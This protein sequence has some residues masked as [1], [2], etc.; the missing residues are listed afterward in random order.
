MFVVVSEEGDARTGIINTKHGEIQTPC[1]LIL[2]RRGGLLNL[3]VDLLDSLRPDLQALHIDVLHLYVFSNWMFPITHQPPSSLFLTHTLPCSTRLQVASIKTILASPADPRTFL[4][5]PPNLPTVFTSRDPGIYEYQG[6]LRNTTDTAI[7]VALFNE[8]QMI[9][10]DT[11]MSIINTLQPDVYT[12]MVDEVPGDAKRSRAEDSV[13]RCTTWAQSSLSLQST[14][15]SPASSIPLLPIHG[16]QYTDL[17]ERSAQNISKIISSSLN[18]CGIYIAGLGTG[19]S[20]SL[21]SQ[22]IQVSLE[23]IKQANNNNIGPRMVSSVSCPED[24]LQ[25]ISLGIDMFDG[26]FIEALTAGGYALC[27]PL[28]LGEMK[29]SIG[30]D[31]KNI[32]KNDTSDGSKLSMWGAIHMRDKG[33]L[34][35]G[36]PCIACRNHS[37]A[38]IHHL[39]VTHEMT[40]QILLEAH[41]SMHML[42]FFTEIRRAIGSKQFEEYKEAFMNYKQHLLVVLK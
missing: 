17:R 24:I 30:D 35:S 28:T 32:I 20:S 36:C 31:D 23:P 9:T 4:A 42:R 38:Y 39:L 8:A 34:V 12:T 25:C 33:T 14:S 37:R 1:L 15:M 6:A 16:A 11:Y 10:L 27:F 18:Q 7:S 40:A 21:R 3:T 13:R 41:N 22:L 5:L 2:S 29:K 19:E 26:G